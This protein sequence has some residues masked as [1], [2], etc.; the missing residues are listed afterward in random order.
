MPRIRELSLPGVFQL[1]PEP[2]VDERG[3]FARYFCLEEFA[4]AGRQTSFV[5]FNQSFNEVSGTLRGMHLQTGA[6]AEDKLVKCVRGAIFDVAVDL[7]RG[8][9]TFLSYAA[10]KLTAENRTALFLPKG[11]AHGFQTLEDATEVIYHH[12]N[13]YRPGHEFGFR[14][15]DPAVAIEWPMAPTR[16]SEKDRSS[17]WL[18][19]NFAGLDPVE[20]TLEQGAR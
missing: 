14:Y 17:P 4:T 5:Q 6:A 19:E 9:P 13:F 11:V 12:S 7:R 20:F 8:S 2:H 1:E 15:D 3:W 10:V 18:P 16:I